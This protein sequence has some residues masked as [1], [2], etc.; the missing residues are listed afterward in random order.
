MTNQKTNN[1]I[2][3]V[4][5]AVAGAVVGAGVAVA[6]AIALGDKKNRKKVIGYIGDVRDQVQ[7]KIS[8]A[9]EKLSKVAGSAQK[10]LHDK[11][12]GSK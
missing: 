3:P 5:A 10:S 1:G 8:D 4:V 12:K 11:A 7:S 6:G 9:E 2:N